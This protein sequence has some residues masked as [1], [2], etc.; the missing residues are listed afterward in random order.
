MRRCAL[1]LVALLC[2][3]STPV[4]AATP[5]TLR[6]WYAAPADLLP[7]QRVSVV[8]ELRS[9][10]LRIVTLQ[11]PAPY[12]L[13][14]RAYYVGSG[15]LGIDDQFASPTP[16]VHWTGA[17]SSTQPINLVLIY[18]VPAAAPPG[19]VVL[20]VSGHAGDTRLA[21]STLVRICCIAAPS[22]RP[23]YR[24]FLPLLMRSL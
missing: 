6:I 5:P 20:S 19:D 24:H 17:V 13:L 14:L 10:V 4:C 18:R 8:I 22:P 7:G 3:L 15:T 9:E 21:A 23:V 1:A 16:S 2:L 12:G 11:H